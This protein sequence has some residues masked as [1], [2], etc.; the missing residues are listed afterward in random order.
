MGGSGDSGQ[1]ANASGSRV[2][3]DGLQGDRSGWSDGATP[4]QAGVPSLAQ[5]RDS[6]LTH[7]AKSSK[8]TGFYLFCLSAGKDKNISYV[9]DP[10]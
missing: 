5:R 3:S 4:S 7:A 6:E 10:L 8:S 2:G 1:F 9:L